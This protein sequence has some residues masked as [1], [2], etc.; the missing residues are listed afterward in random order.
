MAK[1]IDHQSAPRRDAAEQTER[2][3]NRQHA[4]DERSRGI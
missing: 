2:H 3:H 4:N 1:D